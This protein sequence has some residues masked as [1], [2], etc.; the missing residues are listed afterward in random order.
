VVRFLDGWS[1]RGVLVVK[2]T[3]ATQVKRVHQLAQKS[4]RGKEP[5]ILLDDIVLV[6]VAI[7]R[8]DLVTERSC[9][10]H[11]PATINGEA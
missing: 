2:L 8:A 1:Y 5:G 7:I 11:Q 3:I 6:P 10:N 9:K 4:P